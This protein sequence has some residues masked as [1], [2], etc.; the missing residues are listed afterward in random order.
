MQ[1]PTERKQHGRLYIHTLMDGGTRVMTIQWGTGG[2]V[3]I[4]PAE[5][6]SDGII[7]GTKY[8]LLF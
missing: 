5:D 1:T 4:S 8:I 7:P 2:K 3:N 6:R